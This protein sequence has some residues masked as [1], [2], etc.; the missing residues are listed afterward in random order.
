[1][2]LKRLIYVSTITDKFG[3]SSL[4]DI[5]KAGRR[6]NTRNGITGLLCFKNKYFIQCLEGSRKEVNETYNR[7]M[8]DERHSD[9]VLLEYSDIN[10]REFN[11]WCM[12]YIPTSKVTEPL[13]LKFSKS[14]D[15]NPYDMSNTSA[16]MLLLEFK[17][18]HKSF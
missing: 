9:V 13:I 8:V 18:N 12:G 5:L 3:P 14:N 17:K 1:M 2:F 11:D 16:F 6:N 7:I 15:F 4:E 10:S